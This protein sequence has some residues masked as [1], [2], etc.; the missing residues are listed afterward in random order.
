MLKPKKMIFFIKWVKESLLS[1]V[2]VWIQDLEWVRTKVSLE[3]EG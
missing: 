2:K 3:G 1:K